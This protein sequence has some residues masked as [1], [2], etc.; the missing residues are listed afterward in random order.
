MGTAEILFLRR[1]LK[2]S[3]TKKKSNQKVLEMANTEK[4]TNKNNKNKGDE[5]H[6]SYLQKRWN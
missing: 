2:I 4:V 6:G 5:I 3:W 1:I